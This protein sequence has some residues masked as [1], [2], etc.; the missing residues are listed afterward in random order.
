MFSTE[1]CSRY[2][3][4]NRGAKMNNKRGQAALEFLMT[5]G[6]AILSAIIVIGALGSYL[7][8]Q[9]ANPKIF[10]VYEER[11]LNTNETMCGETQLF[12]NSTSAGCVTQLIE[13]KSNKFNSNIDLY[14]YGLTRILY[15]EI[16]SDKK[17]S[18]LNNHCKCANSLFVND[19]IELS[20]KTYSVGETIIVEHECS[21]YKCEGN[22]RTYIVKIE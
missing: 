11:I 19:I 1:L 18:W 4:F 5:Y 8:F 6:W 20:K 2:F 14:E 3:I 10:T 22:K 21:K 9:P 15:N 7:Y 16:G 17:I 13:I 12:Y